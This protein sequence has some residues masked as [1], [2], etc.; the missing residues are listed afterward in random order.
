MESPG[1]GGGTGGDVAGTHCLWCIPLPGYL[2]Q[3]PGASYFGRGLQLADSG[4]QPQAR[5]ANVGAGVLIREGADAHTS[6]QIYLAVVQLVLLYGS[7]TWVLTTRMKRVLGGFRHRVSC[8]LRGRQSWKKQ[9]GIWIYP[10]L[11]D[12]M[13]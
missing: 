5:Q 6:G 4:A 9:D 1:G 2:L 3:V 11:E 13:A 12:A 7:E 10:P 8:R